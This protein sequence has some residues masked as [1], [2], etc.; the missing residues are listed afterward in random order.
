MRVLLGV[1]TAA[2][3]GETGGG[4]ILGESDERPRGGHELRGEVLGAER[5]KT[6]VVRDAQRVAGE[7]RQVVGLAR[8]GL[9]VRVDEVGPRASQLVEER[10]FAAAEHLIGV[11]VLEHHHN[12]VVRCRYR[13]CYRRRRQDGRRRGS[14]HC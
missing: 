8:V 1:V 6:V 12:D 4:Q 14:W 5:R 11:L 10:R 3:A 13:A 7:Q 2:A 9:G